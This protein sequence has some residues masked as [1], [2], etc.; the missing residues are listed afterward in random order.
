MKKRFFTHLSALQIKGLCAMSSKAYKAAKAR[1]SVPDDMTADDWR[2]DGQMEAAGVASLKLATQE[3]Y[4][5]LKGKWFTV[6]GNLEE[7]FYCF[8]N[9]TADHEATRQMRW[10]L[11]GQVAL[12][13]EGIQKS[14]WRLTYS[15][16]MSDAEAARQAWSYT[17]ALA[18]DKFGRNIDSLDADALEQLGFTVVNRANAKLGKGDP[19]RRNRSQRQSARR[20]DD[21][22]QLEAPA[23]A[24]PEAPQGR[25]MVARLAEKLAAR[26][27]PTS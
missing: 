19:R 4:L 6:L 13:A 16:T 21:V 1:G 25:S 14:H 20:P 2:K 22:S 18:H 12:L 24:G 10:R 3:H 7:A 9:G 17:K 27:A 11:M 8:L 5:A 23:S 26:Q 15:D